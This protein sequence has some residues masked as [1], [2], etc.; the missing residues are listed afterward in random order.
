M[1]SRS[2]KGPNQGMQEYIGENVNAPH[3]N[4]LHTP[5]PIHFME[6]ATGGQCQKIARG[7]SA[8]EGTTGGQRLTTTRGEPL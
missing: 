7:Q 5:D 4:N 1:F 6:G 8:L 2:S 3:W